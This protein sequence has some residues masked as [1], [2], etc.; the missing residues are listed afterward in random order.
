MYSHKALALLMLFG[1]LLTGCA[2]NAPTAP[3]AKMPVV[4]VGQPVL[5]EVQDYEIFTGRTETA[6]RV[7]L[8][9]RITGYL[10]KTFFQEGDLV[11]EGDQLFLID[12]RPHKA[13]LS[14]A[15]AN[16]VQAQVR[17]RRTDADFERAQ[18]LHARHAIGREEFDKLRG[19]RDEAHAAVNVAESNLELARLNLKY[20]EI[21]AP[22]NGRVSR[23]MVDPGNLVK[24]DETILTV[25]VALQPIYVYFDVDE[26]TLLRQMLHQ[27]MPSISS[28][29]GRLAISIG[30]AD[31]DGY[32]HA[33]TVNFV[34]NRVDPNTGT[35]WMRGVFENAARLIP[36][37]L[38]TRIRFPLG[39]PYRAVLVA[40]QALGTDQEQK[41]IYVVDDNNVVSYRAVKV[42]QLHD[43]LRV[44][45]DGLRP[46][47][48]VVV[49]GLQRVRAGTEIAPKEVDMQSRVAGAPRTADQVRAEL[50]GAK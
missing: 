12:P 6:E 9:A 31:E 7:D 49:G 30:L 44:I 14:R 10:D 38:F 17:A 37:G 36:P 1:T 23:R 35:I 2:R 32:P 45:K 33:G 20:T 3:A 19:D 27:E 42:G 24:A 22:F 16:L 43:G 8:R 34:D 18:G 46:G 47:E 28:Q 13:E 15:E 4:L 48:K 11:K 29:N 41:F 39:T 26:R 5:K 50:S 21:R 25:L 40:E